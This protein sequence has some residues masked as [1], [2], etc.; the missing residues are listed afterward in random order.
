MVA[1]PTQPLENIPD[2]H[3]ST[4]LEEVNKVAHSEGKNAV[5]V[6]I[7]TYCILFAH[8]VMQKIRLNREINSTMTKATS[9]NLTADVLNKS[10][11]ST[12]TYLIEHDKAYSLINS[13]R[14]RP[15]YWK[16]N[17]T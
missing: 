16:K 8:S 14:G 10:F 2:T 3:C 1:F 9:D 12:V 13:I 17:Y 6:L 11:K 7:D 4:D 5:S 15:V